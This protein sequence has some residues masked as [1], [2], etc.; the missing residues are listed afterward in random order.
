MKKLAISLEWKWQSTNK[1][2]VLSSLEPAM[3]CSQRKCDRGQRVLGLCTV[4]NIVAFYS[5][6][7]RSGYGVMCTVV[8]GGTVVHCTVIVLDENGGWD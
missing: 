4:G 6:P 7:F 3:M 8:S 5:V 2:V 1:D